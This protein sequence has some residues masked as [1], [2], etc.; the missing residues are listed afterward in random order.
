MPRFRVELGLV[1][2]R[3][4]PPYCGEWFANPWLVA[5]AAEATRG[6]GVDQSIYPVF[7]PGIKLERE[8]KC[9]LVTW[10]DAFGLQAL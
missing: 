5:T 10:H 4:M 2:G 1:H 7:V 3:P 8:L 6:I 9:P